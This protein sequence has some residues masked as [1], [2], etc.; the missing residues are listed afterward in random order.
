MSKFHVMQCSAKDHELTAAFHF[1][2]ANINNDVDYSLRTAIVEYLS[3]ETAVPWLEDPEKAQ[4][5]AGEVLEIVKTFGVN[6]NLSNNE[7]VAFLQGLWDHHNNLN[8]SD[9]YLLLLKNRL[10]YWGYNS[11][12]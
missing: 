5:A 4:I 6:A 9:S 8:N 12:T 3:P 2:I 1:P 11:A 10:K 7:K